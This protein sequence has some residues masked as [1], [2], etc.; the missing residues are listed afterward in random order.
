V[1]KESLV[2]KPGDE[3]QLTREFRLPA[4]VSRLEIEHEADLNNNW[5]GLD[6]TL[7]NKNTGETWQASREISRYEGVDD[8]E[9]W[10]EGSRSDAVVFTA[11][12]AGTYV[13]AEDAELPTG[14]RPV[15]AQVKVVR[16]GPR[17]SSL[18]LLFGALALFPIYTYMRRRSFEVTRWAESDH[19]MA[20]SGDGDSDTDD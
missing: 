14:S 20:T 18:F 9:S 17:W 12:T 13:L 15:R 19:P 7:V 10:S 4:A 8:G 16:P 6:L 2:F 3:P 11:L 1:L 5:I